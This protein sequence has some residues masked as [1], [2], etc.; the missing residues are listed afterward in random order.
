MQSMFRRRNKKVRIEFQGS[1]GLCGCLNEPG[2]NPF[3]I[4]LLVPGC[5]E[6]I[7]KINALTIPAHFD[8]LRAA[9]EGDIRLLR[10]RRSADDAANLNDG[11]KFRTIWYRNIVT[12]E[13]PGA[14]AR[15]V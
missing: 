15:D 11:G 4:K 8:H 9:V 6:R 10:M 2:T 7:G 3:R 1:I 13:F 5:I 12:A 14:P